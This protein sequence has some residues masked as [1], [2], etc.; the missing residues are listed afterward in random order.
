MLNEE[1]LHERLKLNMFKKVLYAQ[2]VG[3]PAIP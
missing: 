2:S 3:Y 1:N